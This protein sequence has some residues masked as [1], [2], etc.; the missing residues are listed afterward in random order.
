MRSTFAGLD[1]RQELMVDQVT[2]HAAAYTEEGCGRS[3]MRDLY[4][5][6]AESSS[7]LLTAAAVGRYFEPGIT[8]GDSLSLL[9]SDKLASG[10]HDADSLARCMR[11]EYANDQELLNAAAADLTITAARDPAVV[12]P[13]VPYLFSKGF[14]ALQVHRL[15]HGL[16]T[17]GQ[18]LEAMLWANL[19]ASRMSVDIHPAARLASGIFIDHGDGVVIGETA[20][21][22][23][24]CT[25]LHGVTLGGSGKERGDRHPKIG[26][27]VLLGAN[28]MVL[29]NIKV[30]DSCHI[31][32]GAVVLRSVPAGHVATGV[33]AVHRPISAFGPTP[34]EALEQH[35]AL[36]TGTYDQM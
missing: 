1:P 13:F 34:A 30:G 8:L 6:A 5:Q 25:I 24:G 2:R 10:V 36:Y 11:H 23:T 7:G 32:A 26:S 4:R 12:A 21:V 18:Q 27:E 28:A 9:L 22:G 33:P 15:A 16:W 31:G 17:N 35:V 29:G 20:T 19:C 3:L 14:H